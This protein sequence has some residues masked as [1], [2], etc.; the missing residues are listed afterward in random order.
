MK[1]RLTFHQLGGEEI[2][3]ESF[4]FSSTIP[5]I[6]LKATTTTHLILNTRA[7]THLPINQGI[8]SGLENALN[9][10]PVSNCW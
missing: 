7:Q 2:M 8:V 9:C 1:L 10:K 4:I 3:T 5:L 6:L